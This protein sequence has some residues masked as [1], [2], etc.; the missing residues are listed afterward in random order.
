MVLSSR[1]NGAH[2]VPEVAT[3]PDVQC[4]RR[5]VEHEQVGVRDEGDRKADPLGLPT[6]ELR[7]RPIGDLVDAGDQGHLVH[8]DRVQVERSHHRHEL[9]DAQVLDERPRLEHAADGSCPDRL[10]GWATQHR[11]GPFVR[12]GET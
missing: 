5:L 4:R 2:H 9:A 1:G 12:P 7:R 6:G 10:G 3:P 11:H 8:P